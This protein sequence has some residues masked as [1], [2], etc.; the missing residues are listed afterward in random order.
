MVFQG[1]LA[2]VVY[3]EL[4][5]GNW[6][7]GWKKIMDVLKKGNEILLNENYKN[8]VLKVGRSASNYQSVMCLECKNLGRRQQ[9]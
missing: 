3:G 7:K 1:L 8:A 6:R 2:E 5:S 4:Q 9:Y